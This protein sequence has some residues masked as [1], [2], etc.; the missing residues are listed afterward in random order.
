M[1]EDHNLNIS[2]Q[3]YRDLE[4][5]SY[6]ML[7][8]ISKQGVDVVKGEKMSLN[9]KFGSLVD[10]LCFEPHKVNDIYY[11]GASP[12]LPTKNVK[13]IC[14][15]ILNNTTAKPGES[16]VT[17]SALG[18]RRVAKVTTNLKDYKGQVIAAASALKIYKAYSEEKLMDAVMTG[19]EYFKDRLESRGKVLIK[20]E[21]WALANEAAKTLQFHAFT[22]K[23]FNHKTPGVKIYYQ[24]KFDTKVNN[25]RVKGMLDCLIVN[26]NAKVI[27]PVDLKTGEEAAIHFPQIMLGHRYYI[28]GGLYREALKNIVDTDFDLTGY[29]VNPFE[30]VYLSKMNVQKPMIFEMPETLHQAALN[31]FTDRYGN[32]HRGIY[33]LIEDYYDCVDNGFC[34]YVSDV[35]LK[36]GRTIMDNLIQ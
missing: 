10:H 8:S 30:F 13:D 26:H 2:E 27:I 19:Q 5:P 33:E 1:I 3:V 31:G 25:R 17:E 6:S 24:F 14:D 29:T 22:G 18:R 34:D 11:Q 7:A 4:I 16:Q 15:I 20:P 12:K 36:K 28:Q 35:H 23:Y 32:E 21:M 9:L